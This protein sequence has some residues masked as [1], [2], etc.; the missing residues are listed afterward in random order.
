M[1]TDERRRRA[2]RR[3][4]LLLLAG[5]A[6]TIILPP[7]LLWRVNA[8]PV[9][10]RWAAVAGMLLAGAYALGHRDEP[11]SPIPWFE[12][13]VPGDVRLPRWLGVSL[14][15]VGALLAGFWAT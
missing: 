11:W 3:Y 4:R 7:L 2:A 1:S 5:V 6:G 10:L 15:A 8:P 9:A 12:G 13:L 14:I